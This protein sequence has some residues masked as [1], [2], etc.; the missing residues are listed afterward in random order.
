MNLNILRPHVSGIIW[1]LSFHDWLIPLSILSSGFLHVVTCV[2]I[3]FLFKAEWYSIVCIYHILF[4]Q[5]SVDRHL[6]CF[7]LLV[8]VNNVA[9]NMGIQISPFSS[10]GYTPRSRI[11]GLYGNFIFNFLRN[12][13]TVFQR[14]CTFLHSKVHKC[15]NFST[16]LTTLVILLFWVF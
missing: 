2:R 16:F 7:H 14:G 5:S 11:S 4:I 1:H 15:S 8:S 3:F 10:F 9:V 12:C 13:H 6:G